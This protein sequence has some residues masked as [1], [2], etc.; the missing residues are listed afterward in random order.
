MFLFILSGCGCCVELTLC[1]R[2][3]ALEYPIY[4]ASR[5][6]AVVVSNFYLGVPNLEL[7]DNIRHNHLA[8]PR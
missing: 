7:A 6:S 8:P 2:C 3:Y 4:L 1:L 5:L